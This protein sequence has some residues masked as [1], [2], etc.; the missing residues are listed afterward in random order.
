MP[1]IHGNAVNGK[2]LVSLAADDMGDIYVEL[3]IKSK[4]HQKRLSMELEEL[5]KSTTTFAIAAAPEP[6]L[7]ASALPSPSFST[8]MTMPH[9]FARNA[10]APPDLSMGRKKFGA[11]LSHFK[12]ECGS[13]ARI[14]A[15]KM[16]MLMPSSSIFLDSDDLYDLRALLDDVRASAAFVLFQSSGVLTRPWCLLEIH[17]AIKHSVPIV[18]LNVKGPNPYDY[19]MATTFMAHLDSELDRANPGARKLIEDNGVDIV[20]MAHLLSSTLP[21]CISVDFNPHGSSNAIKASLLDLIEAMEKAEARPLS[22]M[23]SKEEWLR[24]RGLPPERRGGRRGGGNHD[25]EHGKASTAASASDGSSKATVPSTVPE[26]P[27]A[28]QVRKVDLEQLKGCLL[29]SEGGSTAL[30]STKK[31]VGAHG[32]GGVG[33]TTI[34]AA[35]VQ[36]EDVRMAFDKIVWVSLGQDPDILELQNVIHHQ[37]SNQGLP[38]SANN[39]LDI[40]AALRSA[41]KCQSVLLVLDDVWEAKHEK[42]LNCIDPE[43]K[44]RVLVTT[45]V[46]VCFVSWSIWIAF[47]NRNFHAVR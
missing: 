20:E 12:Q 24:K 29:S 3:A 16:R 23:V 2:S 46:S 7:P 36:D 18:C 22:S 38:E 31:K 4:W 5:L 44:S 14:V 10:S 33:K 39:A 25:K 30:T 32:M 6:N 19:G 41:S 21:N 26:L 17:T 42:P 15:D 40:A 27:S 45:R 37:L 11:F 9:P 47:S 43:T 8:S 13:D 34:A 35:L 1:A 28:Y